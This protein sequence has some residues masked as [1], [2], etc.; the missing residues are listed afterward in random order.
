MRQLWLPAL[1][2]VNGVAN[3]DH[4][5][6]PPLVGAWEQEKDKKGFAF[7]LDIQKRSGL[8][9]VQAIAIVKG[10]WEEDKEAVSFSKDGEGRLVKF[11]LNLKKKKKEEEKVAKKVRVSNKDGL[12]II[13]KGAGSKPVGKNVKQQ[14]AAGFKIGMKIKPSKN[15]NP[16][17][18]KQGM[19]VAFES[20][21]A[22]GKN[23]DEVIKKATVAFK[24]AKVGS[25]PTTRVLAVIR[26]AQDGDARL[27]NFKLKET[28]TSLQLVKVK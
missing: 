15:G 1:D 23:L 14:T 7:F 19:S 27:K 12:K 13:K 18:P 10:I 28:K 26:I 5:M 16:F 20:L 24:K 21:L 3:R 25:S 4:G 6:R 2:L 11:K 17:D 8:S 9:L 22:G